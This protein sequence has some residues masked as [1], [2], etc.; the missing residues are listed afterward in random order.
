MDGVVAR[1]SRRGG[2]QEQIIA[3]PSTQGGDGP[4]F[5][6]RRSSSPDEFAVCGNSA[7]S[8]LDNKLS[9]L[10]TNIL[11]SANQTNKQNLR[12]AQRNWLGQRKQCGSN[13]ACLRSQYEAR[14]QELQ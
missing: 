9:Q 4:S 12:I 7:L 8:Q 6:C 14:I 1:F 2:T 10:Y 5:D 13:V 11:Q 3:P